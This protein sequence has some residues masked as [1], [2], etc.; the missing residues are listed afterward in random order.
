VRARLLDSIGPLLDFEWRLGE[1]IFIHPRSDFFVSGSGFDDLLHICS[2]DA[3][4]SKKIIVQR[5]IVVVF[6][7]VSGEFRAAFVRKSGE[8]GIASGANAWAGGSFFGEVFC[9]H[10][11]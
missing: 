2:S 11:E 5:A 3:L 1:T 10:G 7:P 9:S 8:E 4:E 6:A